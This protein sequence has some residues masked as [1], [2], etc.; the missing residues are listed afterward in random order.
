MAK[1]PDSYEG[2]K[3]SLKGLMSISTSGLSKLR[4]NPAVEL[5]RRICATENLGT[6]RP[7]TAPMDPP[8]ADNLEPIRI[9][10]QI[11]RPGEQMLKK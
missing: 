7:S 2:A 9:I 10:Q 1:I 8:R 6:E 3:L 5:P 11:A 4:D